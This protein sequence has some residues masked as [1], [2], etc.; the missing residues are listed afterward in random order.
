M[1]THLDYIVTLFDEGV[2]VIHDVDCELAIS[3]EVSAADFDISVTEVIVNG[4]DLLRSHDPAW[5]RIG[6]K[7][8]EQAETDEWVIEKMMAQEGVSYAGLGG[9]DPDGHYVRRAA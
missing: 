5:K 4:V 1:T 9:N 8:A 3:T 6:M 2:P 7:I